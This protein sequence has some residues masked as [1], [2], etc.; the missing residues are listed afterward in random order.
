MSKAGLGSSLVMLDL[1]S[2]D[3]VTE[4]AWPKSEFARVTAKFTVISM[5][6][7]HEYDLQT[8]IYCSEVVGF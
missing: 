2:D 8:F 3:H 1:M 6:K 7:G 5:A 4:S